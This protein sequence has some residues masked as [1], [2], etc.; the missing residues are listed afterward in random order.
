MVINTPTYACRCLN[1]RIYSQS[2]PK[3]AAL[4]SYDDYI[5]TYV[6]DDGIVIVCSYYTRSCG[7]PSADIVIVA[8]QSTNASNAIKGPP[9]L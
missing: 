9:R 3:D 5:P 7:V 1:V 6:D 4:P 2:N 8:T